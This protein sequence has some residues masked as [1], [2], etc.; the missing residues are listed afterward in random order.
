MRR[1]PKLSLCVLPLAIVLAA[2]LAGCARPG[3]EVLVPTQSSV[4]GAKI[5]TVYV[6]TTRA[7]A[8][9]GMNVF[10]NGRDGMNYA[11]FKISIPPG[12]RPGNIEWPTSTPD[13][14][15]NFVTVEQTVLDARTFEHRIATSNGHQGDVKT[16][17]FVHGYNTNF[18]EAL[19]GLALLAADSDA[20]G[21]PILFA[22]PS[23]AR[24]TGYVADRDA[25]TYSRDQLA[26]LLT[27]LAGDRSITGITLIG[28]SMG[29]WLAVESVR[30]LRLTG[31]NAVVSRL[32]VVLASPD[33]DVDVFREQMDV[34]GPLSPPMTLLVSPDDLALQASSRI[35]GQHQRIGQL[36]VT[37]P[38]VQE[39]ARKAKLYIVDISNLKAPDDLRHDR[40]VT[41][42]SLYPQLATSDPNSSL[43]HAGAFVLNAF[44]E[45]LS[46]PFHAASGVV[47]GE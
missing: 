3:P 8:F 44:G 9:P 16:G 12:H 26:G 35:A 34:I 28:H 19:F 45:A 4:V 24:L 22:W 27:T 43:R 5:V 1:T 6:A 47:E 46:A 21:A 42:A 36:D 10:T 41:L 30:Q 7:R 17:V 29:A 38:R 33:I 14:M 40:Y 39:A 15:T 23:E 11:E 20:G 13:P 31:K 25:V 32:G 2:I 37:D 18:Q